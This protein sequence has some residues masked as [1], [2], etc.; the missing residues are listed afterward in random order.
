MKGVGIICHAGVSHV[1]VV[2]VC[3]LCVVCVC[4]CVCVCECVCVCMYVCMYATYVCVCMC[5][6]MYVCM[7]YLYVFTDTPGMQEK[8][9][10]SSTALQ[11]TSLHTPL[12]LKNPYLVIKSGAT[13]LSLI[14]APHLICRKN[15]STNL[16]N[17]G[18]CALTSLPA[19]VEW[20]G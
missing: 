5:A 7:L 15:H 20:E 8:L 1:C 14:S 2:C 9:F 13:Q 10:Y 3:V 4:V 19:G 12:Y 6:Y 16:F 18:V 11:R 17:L